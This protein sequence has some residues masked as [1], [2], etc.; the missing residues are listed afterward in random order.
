VTKE[1]YSFDAKRFRLGTLCKRGHAWGDT[2][3]SLRR[4][5]N[6]QRVCV[7]CEKIHVLNRRNTPEKEEYRRKYANEYAKARNKLS[8]PS[9][10]KHALAGESRDDA[11]ARLQAERIANEVLL[12]AIRAA[13]RLPSVARLVMESQ[14]EY[15]REHPEA[16]KEHDR[17]WN[18]AKWW[19]EYQTKPELRL[20]TR[21][22]SKR[23]KA[24]ERGSIGI[25]V[26]GCQVKKRFA[27]F[28]NCCAYC[29]A[30]GDL[31]IE[32][33]IPISKGGTHVLSNIVPACQSCNYSKRDKDAEAW[34]RA[35]SFFCKKRWA[36]ILKVMGVSKG[37]PQQLALM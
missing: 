25:Q 1:D 13:G 37:S 3:Q 5:T 33:V 8:R 30:A 36:K 9:R 6:G 22:K 14:R 35:Q 27:E 21:Q 4:A 17:Q 7:E 29:A 20:Y 15:W 23:R 18:Q 2:N 28:G 32:H 19:L 34:Y 16:R 24:L 12:N 11:A 26:K 10:S 31:H